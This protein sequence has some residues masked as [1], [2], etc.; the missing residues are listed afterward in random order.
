MRFRAALIACLALGA[1]T[2]PVSA[3][4]D[5]AASPPAA[6]SA[7]PIAFLTVDQDRLFAES[8]WGKRA[9]ADLEKQSQ[10]LQTE[11]RKIE[12][13]LTAEEKSLTERRATMA[14]ADFCKLA[15]EFDTRVTGIRQAQDA[16]ARDLTKKRDDDRQ[17][18][19]QAA[20]PI[21]GKVMQERGALAILD[22][23]AIFLSVRSIDATTDMIAAIDK[24]LG[25]K[26]LP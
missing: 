23:R 7:A 10:D 3:Q 12:A 8:L 21:M 14:A 20:L 18:F 26:P 11:N 6:Q 1:A 9:E 2:N 22:S 4:S 17:A 13:A 5:P 15:D 24:T 25:D 19:F 16:K